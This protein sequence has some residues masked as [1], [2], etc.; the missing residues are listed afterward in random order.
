MWI[1]VMCLSAVWT[2]ILT[3]PIHCRAYIAEQVMQC[4][5]SPN[6]MKKHNSENKILI[7]YHMVWLLVEIFS[8][9]ATR[10][11][12]SDFPS[13]KKGKKMHVDE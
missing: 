5:I 12:M 1:I 11:A 6:L 8:Q 10:E 4:Y 9:R 2:L 7:R 3:A 13:D